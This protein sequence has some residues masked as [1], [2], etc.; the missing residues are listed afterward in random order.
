MPEPRLVLVLHALVEALEDAGI[1]YA[2]GGALALGAWSEPRATRDIDVTLWVDSGELGRAFKVLRGAGIDVE[3]AKA[4][5][6]AMRDGMFAGRADGVRVDVFVPSIPFYDAA[7]ADRR[8]V[9]LLGRSVLVLSA[10]SLSVFKM[11]FFRRKDLAD[12]ERLLAISDEVDSSAVRAEL[13]AMVGEED[14]RIATWDELV[15]EALRD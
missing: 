3:E 15:A 5:A 1:D 13:V 11:L 9:A 10:T 12:L 8:R 7:L 4:R 6:R 2:I 14:P